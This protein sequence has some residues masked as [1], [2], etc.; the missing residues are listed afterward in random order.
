MLRGL[1]LEQAER[2]VDP[3]RPDLGSDFLELLIGSI[4]LLG[5][6]FTGPSSFADVAYQQPVTQSLRSR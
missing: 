5:R 4:G 6:R 3:P 1:F 2:L